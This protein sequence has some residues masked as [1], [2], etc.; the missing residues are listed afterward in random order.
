MAPITLPMNIQQSC[1]TQWC[2]AAVSS[3]IVQGLNLPDRPGTQG[4]IF[5]TVYSASGLDCSSCCPNGCPDLADQCDIPAEVGM[6]LSTLRLAQNGAQEPSAVG[7]DGIKGEITA[8][9]PVI[10]EI[11]YVDN[12][13]NGHVLLIFGYEAPDV[14]SFGDPADCSVFTASF[15][16]FLKEG[17]Y[18]DPTQDHSHGTWKKV[19]Y[20]DML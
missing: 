1:C 7:F 9:R 16:S 19:Y 12:P 17:A 2:W 8:K 13:D 20:L 11:R 18:V 15:A 6:V 10:A 4:A 14:L 3:T 5:N